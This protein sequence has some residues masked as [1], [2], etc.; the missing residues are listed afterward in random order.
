MRKLIEKYKWLQLLF[1][2]VLV[3]LGVLTIVIPANVKEDNYELITF[4]VWASV[5]FVIAITFVV[6]DLL[7]F[8][9]KADYAVLLIAGLLVGVGI[10]VIVNR[11]IISVVIT[12][13][14]PYILI[15]MG[16]ILLLK[17]IIMAVRRVSVNSWIMPFILGVIILT[18]GI[19]FICVKDLNKVIYYVLG[20]LFVVFG[21]VEIVGFITYLVNKKHNENPSAPSQS[22]RGKKKPV[23]PDNGGQEVVEAQEEP[24][25]IEEQ[26]EAI[27]IEHQEVKEIGAIENE[28]KPE[29]P[30]EDDS[31]KE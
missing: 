15:S 11:D 10:F 25:A 6:F 24:V 4:I 3:A 30:Q 31:P 17:T 16:G 13:L 26:V 9:D 7:A 27:P 19:I 29:E 8:H 20:T 5:L 12:T 14:L 18:A 1:G 23:D 21:A 28:E 2:F 22:R